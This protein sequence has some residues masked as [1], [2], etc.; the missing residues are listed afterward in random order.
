MTH[1]QVGV[2]VP[3]LNET[4]GKIHNLAEAVAALNNVA[5]QGGGCAVAGDNQDTSP[6][7][8]TSLQPLSLSLQLIYVLWHV[9]CLLL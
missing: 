1:T 9:S 3:S 2:T 5:E 6:D 4:A 7:P 8:G